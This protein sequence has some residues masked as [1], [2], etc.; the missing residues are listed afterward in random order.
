LKN[1]FLQKNQGHKNG[2]LP[3]LTVPSVSSARLNLPVP[4]GS[5][6]HPLSGAARSHELAQ[7]P[8]WPPD[9]T[10]TAAATTATA[11]AADSA[12]TTDDPSPSSSPPAHEPTLWPASAATTATTTTTP[13]INY[14]TP[15]NQY[16]IEYPIKC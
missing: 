7:R 5:P 4:N 2:R 10:T 6:Q 1:Q 13:T 8:H 12:P 14:Q 15:W 11:A 16:D 9:A 3:T